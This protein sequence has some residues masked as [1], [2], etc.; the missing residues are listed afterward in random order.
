V[1]FVHFVAGSLGFICVVSFI[2]SGD[3][4]LIS[5]VPFAF[6]IIVLI[7]YIVCCP[8]CYSLCGFFEFL[9]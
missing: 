3:L 5:V 6:I 7:V 2:Y 4:G 1:K 8:L 9:Q